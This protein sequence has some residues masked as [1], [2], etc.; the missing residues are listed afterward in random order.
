MT[1]REY[2]TAVLS[3]LRH[4]TESEKEQ[5][6]A[7]L[8]AH[9]EDH[10]LA[11]VEYG[12]ERSEA[13][14]RAALSMGD[15]AEVSRE[16]QKCYAFGW[17][18][19]QRI[20]GVLLA[21]AV[22]VAVTETFG[23]GRALFYNLQ[24]RFDPMGHMAESV[25]ERVKEEVDYRIECGN[26]ILRIYALGENERGELEVFWCVRNEKPLRY[27]A[28]NVGIRYYA[29]EDRETELRAGGG[30]FSNVFVRYGNDHLELPAGAESVFVEVSWWDEEET[31]EIPV[32]WEVGA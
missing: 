15:P 29:A 26:S 22:I 6:R 17:L 28:K 23:T 14:K 11:L 9:M 30:Y 31:V 19:L 12:Y 32:G 3:G 4:V 27:A 16:L 18:V 10:M 5:I 25:R 8:D 1:R 7:E 20:L 24:A 13:E 21:L 2:T